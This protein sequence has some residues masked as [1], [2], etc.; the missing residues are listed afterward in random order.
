MDHGDLSI[1]N[2]NASCR[3]AD[4]RAGAF[5]VILFIHF[6]QPS[7]ARGCQADHHV[8]AG[9]RKKVEFLR[10]RMNR[11]VLFIPSPEYAV[12]LHNAQAHCAAVLRPGDPHGVLQKRGSDSPVPVFRKDGEIAQFAFMILF[13]EQ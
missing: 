7:H 10:S 12:F 9:E 5:A 1:P 6:E 2:E 8:A 11:S 4:Q 13:Q 3:I